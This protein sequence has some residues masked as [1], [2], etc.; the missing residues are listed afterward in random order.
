LE[1]DH[2]EFPDELFYDIDNDV[3][4]E[5]NDSKA[6]IG[7]TSVLLF[8]AGGIS[9]VKLKQELSQVVKGQSIGTIESPTF[10]GA[11]RSPVDAEI[12]RF[13]E[14]LIEDP[15]SLNESPYELGWIAEL[16]IKRELPSSLLKG[17]DARAEL[18][19]RIKE[20]RVK[21]FKELPDEKVVEVGTECSATLAN[22][23]EL[24]A[25]KPIGYKVHL[26]TDE[27]GADIEMIRWS[28]QTRNEVLD[29]RR[30]EK[31]YHFLVKKT[32]DS[33]T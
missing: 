10:F 14:E 13:N 28:D 27:P 17:E 29:F 6:R 11:V 3:W 1:I 23:N 9:K 7:I 31:F 33:R 30:E 16:S 24:L 26:V 25:K 4:L 8:L 2:C 12:F 22:L 32:I 19:A 21:C 20:L 5:L 18:Q 15:H